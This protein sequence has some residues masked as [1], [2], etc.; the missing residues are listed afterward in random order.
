MDFRPYTIA[1]K[2]TPGKNFRKLKNLRKADPQAEI[3]SNP[4][5]DLLKYIDILQSKGL[6]IHPS[7]NLASFKTRNHLAYTG[8]L[9]KNY[10]NPNEILLKIPKNILL[11]TK[12]A[13]FSEMQHV[14]DENPEFYSRFIEKNW[15]D[16]ILLTFL[17]YE[18]QKK[19][20]SYWHFLIKLLP[21]DIDYLGFW[22]ESELDLLEDPYL[23][24]KA[25]KLL[26]DFE[27]TYA[28]LTTILSK[29]PLKFYKDTYS[30]ENVKWIHIHLITRS[31]GG[32]Y[33][34]YVTMVPFAEFFNHECTNV[35]YDFSQ[36]LIENS[37]NFKENYQVSENWE[38]SLSTSNES[39]NSEE[40]M[41][42][43]DFSEIKWDNTSGEI[44]NDPILDKK[45][46]E[47]ENIAGYFREI[48]EWV[49]NS[50]DLGDCISCFYF[51]EI[52]RKLII[53]KKNIFKKN[54]KRSQN[55][56][57]D[58]FTKLNVLNI[59]YKYHLLQ[60]MSDNKGLDLV[61][62]PI[63]S[64]K[65]IFF[66]APVK[67]NNNIDKDLENQKLKN[68]SDPKLWK[69]DDFEYMILKNSEKDFFYKNS[70]V[71]FC[72]GRLSNRKLLMRYGLA[73]EYNKYDHVFI[74]V[75]LLEHLKL[76][77]R[78]FLNYL[79]IFKLPKNKVF[80]MQAIKF[81]LDFL[82]FSKGIY[83]NMEQNNVEELF[84]PLNLELELKG[85]S[86][87]KNIIEKKL[88]NCFKIS[89]KDN[90][91]QIT[92]KKLNYHEHFAVI[93]RVERQKLLIF[94]VKIVNIAIEIIK[95]LQKGM[96]FEK[97]KE[98][99]E[100]LEESEEWER[101]RWVLRNYLEKLLNK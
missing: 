17:L 50:I 48:I 100:E 43:D 80:K 79:N 52:L 99:I 35:Y 24:E 1:N 98:R 93:Y 95:K 92:D 2:H 74:K 57:K 34:N 39:N 67:N 13:Y 9:T 28:K 19:E 70:Q 81:N 37:E 97:A 18:F 69:D 49:I 89:F 96:H 62:N 59:K 3:N 31:F 73:L 71:Y 23:K 33:L 16:N 72:Y 26:S 41:R 75:G 101:N 6:E 5:P 90:S 27:E 87:M 55:E 21:R 77:S 14:F 86:L 85:L 4:S 63:I 60:Y 22:S 42:S 7:L 84:E 82:L 20:L 78:D 56:M 36:N 8:I 83:W 65:K 10:I 47:N 64:Q 12:L 61:A 51:H 40:S 25:L 44:E 66:E 32:K 30:Y 68:L 45:L 54:D 15:E 11:T 76:A 91:D 38:D 53:L 88:R 58:A 46:I 29:Y 94:H